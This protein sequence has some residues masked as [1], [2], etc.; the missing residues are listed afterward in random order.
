[1]RILM[2]ITDNKGEESTIS[3]HFGHAPFFAIY[4]SE[5]ENLEI[6]NNNLNHS[7]KN[8]TPVDQIIVHNP[9]IVYVLE[10]G[11]RAISLFKE[12][13]VKLRTGDFTK[14]R[15]VLN[16]INSCEEVERGCSH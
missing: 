10:I 12:K 6:I 15:E 14:V 3:E 5:K 4:D 9:D 7:D 16:N 8:I 1:M 2:P 11:Q 13:G